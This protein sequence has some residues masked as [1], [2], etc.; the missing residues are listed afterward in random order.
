MDRV[1]I[2]IIIVINL[3]DV[4]R[5]PI[6]FYGNY[7]EIIVSP[8]VVKT[9]RKNSPIITCANSVR[10]GSPGVMLIWL[11]RV[12]WNMFY[13]VL[14]CKWNKQNKLQNGQINPVRVVWLVT[15][16]YYTKKSTKTTDIYSL[17]FNRI[18]PFLSPQKPTQHMTLF[19]IIRKFIIYD[20][21][22]LAFRRSRT[23][24]TFYPH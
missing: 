9:P 3:S 7:T 5:I 18:N 6:M 14:V 22:R 19:I 1:I 13:V 17:L 16:S 24:N 2:S 11:T 8:R 15:E 21:G 12:L 23:K 4:C 20:T 10:T